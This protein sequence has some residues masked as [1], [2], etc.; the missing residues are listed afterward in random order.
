MFS[1]INVKKNVLTIVKQLKCNFLI[2][3]RF[4]NIIFSNTVFL[5]IITIK[6]MYKTIAQFKLK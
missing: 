6:L 1:R 3:T 4:I 2:T 5:F